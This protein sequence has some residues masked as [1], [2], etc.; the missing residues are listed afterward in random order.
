MLSKLM[1]E[2]SKHRGRHNPVRARTPPGFWEPRWNVA[3]DT[4]TFNRQN[5]ALW[6]YPLPAP[7]N[8]EIKTLKDYK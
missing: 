5:N 2:C 1:G 6:P 4:D 8:Y 3:D 7:P